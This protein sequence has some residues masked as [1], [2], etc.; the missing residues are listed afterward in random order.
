MNNKEQVEENLK[1][2]PEIYTEIFKDLE[3]ML[4]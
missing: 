4:K 3:L 2:Y 1:F